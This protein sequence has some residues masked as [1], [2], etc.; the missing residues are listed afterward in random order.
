MIGRDT[1]AFFHKGR[2]YA[3]EIEKARGR[4]AFDLI[5]HPSAIE[6]DSVILEISNLRHK[7]P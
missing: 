3:A 2:D 6:P 5:K 7:E 1:R 4:W